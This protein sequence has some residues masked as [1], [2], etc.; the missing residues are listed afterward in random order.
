MFYRSESLPESL[1]LESPRP[2]ESYGD[3]ENHAAFRFI[4]NGHLLDC[5]EMMYWLFVVNAIHG[6]LRDDPNSKAQQFARRG[7]EI[8]VRRIKENETGF[9]HRHHGTW[10]MLRSCTRSALMLIAAAR[11]GLS[12]ILPREWEASIAKV[13]ELLRYWQGEIL[14]AS[15]RLKVLEA[16]MKLNA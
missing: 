5:Y 1:N 13:M 6:R 2:E 4:L 7:L 11:S 12:A 10:L 16:L 14:D 8:C 15:D 9:R 3:D